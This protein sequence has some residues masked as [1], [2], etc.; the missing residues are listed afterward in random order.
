ME[1]IQLYNYSWWD[2]IGILYNDMAMATSY[3]QLAISLGLDMN[4][5][6]GFVSTYNL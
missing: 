6:W 2:N 3:I 4:H 1:D 5:K